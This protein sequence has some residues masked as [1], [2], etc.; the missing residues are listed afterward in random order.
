MSHLDELTAGTL[1]KC[2][3]PQ[4]GSFWAFWEEFLINQS[5]STLLVAF[6]GAGICLIK[7][8]PV[9]SGL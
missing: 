4:K 2:S 5:R 3:I 8:S 6:A 9:S 1:A 7:F